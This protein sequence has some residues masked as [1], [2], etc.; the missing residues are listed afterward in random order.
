MH[1]YVQALLTDGR[2]VPISVPCIKIALI[3]ALITALAVHILKVVDF[4][5]FV[6][7]RL[8]LQAAQ[9]IVITDLVDFLFALRVAVLHVANPSLYA[10]NAVFVGA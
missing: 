5:D 9:N 8:T 10:L 3:N 7:D 6:F 4:L 2:C 1:T